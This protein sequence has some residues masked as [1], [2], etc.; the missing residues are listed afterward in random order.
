MG[1]CEQWREA[2]SAYADGQCRWAERKAVEAHLREC[3]DCR[4]WLEDIRADQQLFT[5]TVMG[6]QAD[7]SDTVMSRVGEMSAAKSQPMKEEKPLASWRLVKAAAVVA[8]ACLLVAV[9]FPVFTTARYKARPAL[10]PPKEPATSEALQRQEPKATVG[11]FDGRARLSTA[12]RPEDRET[13]RLAEKPMRVPRAPDQAAVVT[14]APTGA[15]MPSAETGWFDHRPGLAGETEDS[16]VARAHIELEGLPE[17]ATAVTT[18]P[19]ERD[20]GM[21]RELKLAYDAALEMWVKNVQEAVVTAEQTFYD[22]GGFV[23]T[24]VLNQAEA[25]RESR[26]AEIIGK[27]PTTEVAE[28]INAL[29]ALGYVARREIQGEDITDQ[30]IQTTRD[31]TQIK[32]EIQKLREQRLRASRAEKKQ[33]DQKIAAAQKRLGPAQD[34]Y[35]DVQRELALATIQATLVE[36]TPEVSEALSGVRG[37]WRSFTRAVAKVGVALV[38]VGLYGLFFVPMIVAVIIYWRR[39]G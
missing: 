15:G 26:R 12:P 18:G 8:A 29:A 11:Y 19:P 39:R 5:Q 14:A 17:A 38:W 3:A 4:Q 2:I 13:D 21:Q 6:H 35:F 22:R 10:T 23:L 16:R 34:E 1:N 9:L 24:S 7:I 20:W 31:I 25:R 28:T 33:I 32:D 37:A 30:Y 27:V 36:K